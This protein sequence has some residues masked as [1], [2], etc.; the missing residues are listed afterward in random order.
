MTVIFMHL[1]NSHITFWRRT[2]P[3]SL[4]FHG[5]W[6]CLC[7]TIDGRSPRSAQRNTRPSPSSHIPFEGSRPASTALA[8]GTLA[9]EKLPHER[10]E[11][12][13]LRVGKAV[14]VAGFAAPHKIVDRDPRP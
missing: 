4:P 7:R 11:V 13:K 1:R 14:L 8:N 3:L 2:L 5:L 10:M 9:V 6:V 12:G